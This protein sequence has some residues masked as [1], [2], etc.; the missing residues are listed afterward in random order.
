MREKEKMFSHP[1]Y[2]LYELNINIW[3]K[4]NSTSERNFFV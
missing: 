3:S 1:G 2:Q 4:V